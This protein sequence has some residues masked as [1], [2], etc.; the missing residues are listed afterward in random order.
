MEPT[1]LLVQLLTLL[2]KIV[3]LL[4]LEMLDLM[5]LISILHLIV[6]LFYMCDQIRLR[7]VQLLELPYHLDKEGLLLHLMMV[8]SSFLSMAQQQQQV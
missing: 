5:E 3:Q 1:V 6:S 7:V 2:I 8:Q 4:Q